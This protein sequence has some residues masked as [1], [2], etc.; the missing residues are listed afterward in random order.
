MVRDVEKINKIDDQIV[1]F[2]NRSE[3][4]YIA[5]W[6]FYTRKT[7]TLAQLSESY[8]NDLHPNLQKFVVS[9]VCFTLDFENG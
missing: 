5:K 4:V 2:E 3:K 8:G 9:E 1:D 7:K 6:K